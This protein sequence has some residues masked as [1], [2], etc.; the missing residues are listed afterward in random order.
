M[1]SY[2]Q[3][4]TLILM[5][6]CLAS[7]SNYNKEPYKLPKNAI[8]LLSGTSGKSWKIAWRYNGKTRMN[9][10]GCFLSYKITYHPD[11]TIKDNNGDYENCGPSL[12]GNW[13]IITDKK[14]KSFI[15]L[16][17]DQLPEIMNIKQN[18]KFFKILKIK[19]DTLQLQ[20]RHKQFSS[21]ST[22]IDTYVTEHI[23]IKDRDFHW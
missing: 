7:C 14:G 17:S 2:L 21:E 3:I 13:E 20:Y 16:T 5:F 10:R 15:K 18:Y 9:M 22:F 1:R 19:K 4:C 11:M 23:K 12:I 6:S 8:Q